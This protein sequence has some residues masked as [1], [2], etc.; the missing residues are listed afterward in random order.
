MSQAV[1]TIDPGFASH[2]GHSGVPNL[3]VNGPWL[4]GTHGA[5]SAQNGPYRTYGKMSHMVLPAPVQLIVMTEEAPYSLNDQ[6][7]AASANLTSPRWIDSPNALHNN[8]CVVSFA[9]GHVELHKW[10]GQSL[11]V[12]SF[13]GTAV[14]PNDPDFTWVAQRISAHF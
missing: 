12:S 1:G 14:P 10:L 3:P 2:S 13:T 7:L 8:A 9:D 11:N 5:N 4:T 6:G